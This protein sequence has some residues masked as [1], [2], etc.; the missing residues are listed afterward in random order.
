MQYTANVFD[1]LKEQN[2]KWVNDYL[3]DS[4]ITLTEEEIIKFNNNVI[5]DITSEKSL[6]HS[7]HACLVNVLADRTREYNPNN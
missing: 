5:L 2:I 4:E 6:K 7:R 3:E 1:Y